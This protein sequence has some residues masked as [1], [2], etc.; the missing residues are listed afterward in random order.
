MFMDHPNALV[1]VRVIKCISMTL[2]KIRFA[3]IGTV[4]YNF[5]FYLCDEDGNFVGQDQHGEL[6]LG[7]PCIGLGYL[8]A[9]DLSASKFVTINDERGFLRYVYRTG[10]IFEHKSSDNKLHFVEKTTK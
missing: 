2:S 5:D 4:S 7:G 9:T 3:P 6:V 1:F 10:D 8:G